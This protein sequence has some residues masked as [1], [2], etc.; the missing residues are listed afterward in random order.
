VN[1]RDRFALI[2]S[3]IA[4]D[5]LRGWSIGVWFV[6]SFAAAGYIAQEVLHLAFEYALPCAILPAM[7]IGT[8][9][10]W[11]R[12]GL[13]R[14]SRR[15]DVSARARIELSNEYNESGESIKPKQVR[16]SPSGQAAS[17]QDL[18]W[19]RLA[20]R[21]QDGDEYAKRELYE[22][23]SKA[24]RFMLFRH[25]GSEDLDDKVE[26]VFSTITRSIQNG[27]LRDPDALVVF[28]HMMVRRQIVA[29]KEEPRSAGADRVLN[30]DI[31][32]RLLETL[33]ERDREALLRFYFKEESVEEICRA[34]NLTEMQLR[35]IKARA[36]QRVLALTTQGF[37][38]A[39]NM[40]RHSRTGGH[41][42]DEFIRD[43]S[44]NEIE[45][46]GRGN[47]IQRT[48]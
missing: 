29:Y 18:K 5:Y 33:P 46:V 19:R 43:A 37:L 27:G 21:I 42:L 2:G 16:G 26:E 48:A 24:V 36:K 20:L 31:V 4:N 8:I 12:G 22:I 44:E 47:I 3:S 17:P 6:I 10:S 25:L 32:R 7:V 15:I 14:G 30:V 41:D 38:G 1:F 9:V 34:L 35:L 28:I 13:E 39:R 11:R 23:F 40:C 45:A